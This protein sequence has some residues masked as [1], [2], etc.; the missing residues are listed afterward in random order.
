MTDNEFM[1]IGITA[2]EEGVILNIPFYVTRNIRVLYPFA[3]VDAVIEEVLT[4]NS[5][6]SPQKRLEK[7]QKQMLDYDYYSIYYS[8]IE[9]SVVNYFRVSHTTAENI[10]TISP[11]NHWREQFEEWYTTQKQNNLL[12]KAGQKNNYLIAAIDDFNCVTIPDVM[13]SVALKNS[14]GIEYWYLPTTFEHIHWSVAITHAFRTGEALA[15][16]IDETTREVIAI[17]ELRQRQR[18]ELL[19]K[20]NITHFI[21]QESLSHDYFSKELQI[22]AIDDSSRFGTI[23]LNTPAF[24]SIITFLLEAFFEEKVFTVYFLPPVKEIDELTFSREECR[25]HARDYFLY[26]IK[27]EFHLYCSWEDYTHLSIQEKIDFWQF[28]LGNT[29]SIL[30]D[31]GYDFYDMFSPETYAFSLSKEPKI[32]YY[33]H[34]VAESYDWDLSRIEQNINGRSVI[35]KLSAVENNTRDRINASFMAMENVLVKTFSLKKF[36]EIKLEVTLM[37]CQDVYYFIPKYPE[38][39]PWIMKLIRGWREKETVSFSYNEAT[40]EV[41]EIW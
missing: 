2:H 26:Y 3:L 17:K 18:D 36:P 21:G 35:N 31:W 20:T 24:Y 9:D 32:D 37:G 12:V 5:L 27:D 16:K 23:D 10:S 7:R 33:Y 19:V 13:M 6:V 29:G 11:G 40:S 25:Q 22:S 15:F 30:D 34:Q 14:L 39:K 28:L 38:S 1:I 4:E 41:M 8:F